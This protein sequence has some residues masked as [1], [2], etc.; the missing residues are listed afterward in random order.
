MVCA[1]KI[2]NTGVIDMLN[3]ENQTTYNLVVNF[4]KI[5]YLA[6]IRENKINIIE[7]M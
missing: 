7:G 3:N 4:Y 6:C 2:L 1:Q 5:Y